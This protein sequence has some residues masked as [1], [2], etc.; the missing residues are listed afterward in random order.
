MFSI[1][2]DIFAE[3]TH[4]KLFVEERMELWNKDRFRVADGWG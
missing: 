3:G 2:E 4:L 1:A